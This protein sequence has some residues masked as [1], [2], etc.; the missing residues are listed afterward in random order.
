MQ[1]D[2]R[3][4]LHLRKN[5]LRAALSHLNWKGSS[6]INERMVLLLPSAV[7]AL[8]T[9]YAPF[10]QCFKEIPLSYNY[11]D[12]TEALDDC[13]KIDNPKNQCLHDFL[14]C[15]VEALTK[16][17]KGSKVEVYQLQSHPLVRLPR[18]ISDQLLLEMETIILGFVEEETKERQLPDIFFICSILSNFLYGSFSTRKINISFP[19]RLSQ[20][21][22]LMLDYA[23]SIIQQ[24]N[25]LRSL[26][27]LS[28]DSSCDERSPIVASIRS[29]L[30]SPIF[31]EWRY[32]N[33]SEFVPFAEIIQT[34]ERLLK[35]FVKSYEDYSQRITNL[36]SEINVQDVAANDNTQS[37][38]QC[39]INKSRIM[40]VE[41]DVNDD[42]G[43]VDILAVGK[44]I[45]SGVSFSSEKWKMSMVLLITCF[46]AVSQDITWDMLFNLLE[47]ESDSKVRGKMLYYL[48]Q[49]PHWSSCAKFIELLNLMNDAIKGQV[50]MKLDCGNVL[51][52]T[53]GLLSTLTSLDADGKNKCGLYLKEDDETDKCFL[54][55]GNL[56]H[57][58]AEFD[59]DWFGRVKLIDCICDL[60]LLNPQ[61]G[62]S[63]IERLLMM[64]QDMDFRVR[65][66]L[67][68]RIGI[69]FQ[70]WDGHEE[71]FQ[72]IC[73][74]FGVPMVIHSK[75]KIVTAKE[76]LTA[77]PQ[78][79][80]AVETVVLTLM[81]LALQSDKIELEAVFMISVVS[82]IDPYHRDLVCATL[83]NLSKELQYINRMKYLEEHLGSIIFCW[84]ACGVS[85]VSLVEASHDD[86]RCQVIELE[87]SVEQV[88]GCFMVPDVANAEPDCFL[89]YCCH[90][91]LPSLLLHEN[92]SDLNWIAKIACQPLTVLIKNHFASVFSVCMALHC[93]KKPESGKATHVLQS[94]ILHFA[95]ISESERDKL[96]K[97]HMVSIVSY[98]LSLTSCSSDPVI[99]FF[100]RETV[101]CAI[102]A[103]VDGFLETADNHTSAGVA[104]KINIFRPDRVFMFM[105]EMHYK[106][107]AAIHY[108]HKCHHL[109][110]IE[111]LISILGHRAAVPSTSYYL[112]NL[113]GPFI[114][115]HALQD[116][117]IRIVHGLLILL[118][119]NPSPESM[120]AV[121]EQLQFLVSNLVACC[122]PSKGKQGCHSTKLS[123]VLSLLRMLTVD[124]DPSMY[125]YIRELEPFPELEIFDEIRKFHEELCHTYSIR[126]ILLKFVKR[127]CFLPP[128][129]LLSS[130]Q[131][132]HKKLMIGETF[133]REGTT[134]DLF[135]DRCWHGDCEIVHAVWT[136]VRMCGS[137]DA[138][139]V[140]ELVSDFMSRVGAG[141]PYSVVFHVPGVATYIHAGK[142]M[143]IGNTMEVSSNI[144]TCLPKE[145]L[146][147]LMKFLKKYLMDDSVKTVDMASQTLRVLCCMI[148][149]LPF[150]IGNPF[151]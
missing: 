125:D 105:V 130:L 51:A 120:S 74:N 75:G 118:E 52:A 150:H 35:A 102:Q 107:A 30:S 68:R 66:F 91:L 95:Q 79:P 54:S 58:L 56:V 67:A 7:Y 40:D 99:P 36:Q 60:V 31:N 2:L 96:I 17:D 57:K 55:L 127:S 143:D 34:V 73:S 134:E 45:A 108:R 135:K 121:G 29:F 15:S 145:L 50:R 8:C 26:N 103:V 98:I 82:A 19:S 112:F 71:L 142:S 151:N 132:L 123:E 85:L 94:S 38:W 84:V 133:L 21:L 59:L 86:P 128:R 42:S 146:I 136:L 1:V 90:W 44:N 47:K 70:T 53:H 115:C 93:S 149:V 10:T 14:D 119:K 138:S 111:V 113:V 13:H 11:L 12:I 83:D 122:I 114:G 5:L 137:N 117:C 97:R 124:S 141:D 61:T 9:G 139:S 144:D 76:V 3:D 65:L 49:H 100:S 27:C 37:S 126:D 81:H 147:V 39:E 140:R 87:E 28:Y 23:V 64:L 33:A 129:V 80:S 131:A 63:M 78:P 92:R 62:Q 109:A 148:L 18:E 89:Q 6:T 41:L 24:D 22:L 101:S 48:C 25:D 16:I 4:I 43:D 69:L 46:F 88:T 104:D 110:G 20:Y 106:I 77:G 116:Q 32:Q 72:D